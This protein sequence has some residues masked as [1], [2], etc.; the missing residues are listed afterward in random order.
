M[1][2]AVPSWFQFIKNTLSEGQFVGIYYPQYPASGLETRKK[3]FEDAG[4]TVKC[5]PDLVDAVWGDE[6]PARPANPVHVLDL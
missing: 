6:R 2:Q 1:E 5:V 3:F 4:L